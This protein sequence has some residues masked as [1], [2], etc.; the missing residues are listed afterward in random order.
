[1]RAKIA[2]GVWF[3]LTLV[4]AVG[5]LA[6]LSDPRPSILFMAIT[7]AIVTAWLGYRILRRPTYTVA[8]IAACVGAFFALFLTMAI[9]QG[10]LTPFPQGFVAIALA[11]VAGGLPLL[12]SRRNR[13]A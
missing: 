13:R 12:D 5:L 3:L 9:L 1:V 10:S 7:L 11:A 8:I 4:M 6:E 2:A